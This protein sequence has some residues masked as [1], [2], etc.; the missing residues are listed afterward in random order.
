MSTTLD[1]CKED[2]RLPLISLLSYTHATMESSGLDDAK[3]PDEE[4]L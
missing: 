2:S 1:V 3:E 4:N